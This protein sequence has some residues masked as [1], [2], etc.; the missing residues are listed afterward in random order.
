MTCI[1]DNRSTGSYI[2]LY[3][4]AA[5]GRVNERGSE[6]VGKLTL[7]YDKCVRVVVILGQAFERMTQMT[8]LV[9]YC[10]RAYVTIN[11]SDLRTDF[12]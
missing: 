4:V 12:K 2:L 10:Y 11:P 6:Y 3:H 9:S 7:S 8:Q 1:Y 5:R